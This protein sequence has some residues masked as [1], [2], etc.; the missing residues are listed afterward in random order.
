[1]TS[2]A[3]PVDVAIRHKRIAFLVDASSVSNEQVD[4]IISYNCRHWGGRFNP[5]IPIED[6][7]VSEGWWQLLVAVD[8]DIIY[9]LVPLSDALVD[10]INREILPS[11]IFEPPEAS[12]LVARG[13]A[14]GAPFDVAGLTTTA[15]PRFLWGQRTDW[16]APHFQ[17]VKDCASTTPGRSFALRN[18]GV[19]PADGLM[20]GMFDGIPHTEIE[21]KSAAPSAYFG[22]AEAEPNARILFPLDLCA[23]FARPA[24]TPN[25]DQRVRGFRLVV[26]DSPW[27]G[28]YSWNLGLQLRPGL[29]SDSL[30]LPTSLA[31]DKDL[32]ASIGKW[33]SRVFWC[34]REERV[35]LVVSSG[36]DVKVRQELCE[37]V[38][39]H[40]GISFSESSLE[41]A[42]YPYPHLKFPIDRNIPFFAR[43]NQLSLMS[44]EQLAVAD[45]K[46]MV[47]LFP[48]PFANEKVDHAGWM[49]DLG[50]AFRPERFFYTNVRPKW[51]LPK[52]LGLARQFVQQGGPT[53]RVNYLGYPSFE[54]AA[55][56]NVIEVSVPDDRSIIWAACFDQGI[57]NRVS[58]ASSPPTPRRFERFATSDKGRHL[59]GLVSLFGTV[60]HARLFFSDPFWRR[61]FYVLSDRS[62]TQE[63][64]QHRTALVRERISKWISEQGGL[65]QTDEGI[66]DL[67]R[68]LA[69]ELTFRDGPSIAYS[70]DNFKGM[71]AKMRGEAIRDGESESYWKAHQK[72]DAL[73][74][75]ELS[76]LVSRRVLM[77]GMTLRCPNCYTSHWH[78]SEE[79][80]PSIGCESCMSNFQLPLNGEWSFRLNALV[81]NS[82][83]HHGTTSVLQTLFRIEDGATFRGMFQYLPAQDIFEKEITPRVSDMEKI[84]MKDGRLTF[85]NGRCFSDVDLLYVSAGRFGVVEVKSRPDAFSDEELLKLKTIVAELRPDDLVLA[86]SGN[87][88]P[89]DVYARIERLTGDLLPLGV[90]VKKMLVNWG[91]N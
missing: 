37:V 67:S 57:S 14:G 7:N 11:R 8:P 24:F 59:R 17:Y 23:Q 82:I 62:Y 88:W 43:N 1:M 71:F 40:A 53:G 47:Q 42:S 55:D 76:D 83:R 33:I 69:G 63:F 60:F 48:P 19:L 25:Y 50:I 21:S 75:N 5:I 86:A 26:G 38:S 41:S 68:H 45:G 64:E 49:V 78:G 66:E 30:W 85:T 91:C 9:S 87:L 36:L 89:D 54:V 6:S 35:G 22:D 51:T 3:L 31:T 13:I 58:R 74:E 72:F 27:A 32:L 28:I 56:T 65:P 2:N 20:R 81:V 34:D 80:S 77:Q 61:A 29:G 79:L 90:N 73:K 18:F 39:G 15:I 46:L 44:Q 12:A 52:R 10:R 16:R 4:E 70:I 84:Q